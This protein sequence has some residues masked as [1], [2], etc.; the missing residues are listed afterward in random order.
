M[1]L[2]LISDGGSWATIWFETYRDG[3]GVGG[4]DFSH[5]TCI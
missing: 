1:L 2:N 3:G 4:R 5:L